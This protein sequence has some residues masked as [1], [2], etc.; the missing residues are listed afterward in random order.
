VGARTIAEG[1]ACTGVIGSS[2]CAVTTAVMPT[3]ALTRRQREFLQVLHRSLCTQATWLMHL[4][5]VEEA[6]WQLLMELVAALGAS[7]KWPLGVK[8]G[9]LPHQLLLNVRSALRQA[10]FDASPQQQPL[11]IH[12]LM[13]ALSGCCTG[14][15]RVRLG[16]GLG[17]GDGH[18]SSPPSCW[19]LPVTR[20]TKTLGVTWGSPSASPKR[21]N[22]HSRLNP[23]GRPM[24]QQQQEQKEE[25]QDEQQ[26]KQ[27]PC[28][29]R[30][31]PPP[32]PPHQHHQASFAARGRALRLSLDIP[33]DS[34]RD[35]CGGDG[36]YTDPRGAAL[37]VTPMTATA[38]H[39]GGCGGYA[40]ASAATGR[41]P[42]AHP[43][44]LPSFRAS[45]TSAAGV[46][47]GSGGAAIKPSIKRERSAA[48][49]SV[50][51]PFSP[52]SSTANRGSFRST[53]AGAANSGGPAGNAYSI[54]YERQLAAA[55]AAASPCRAR[56]PSPG[57]L[58][59]PSHYHQQQQQQ[60]QQQQ[61][62]ELQHQGQGQGRL[63][64]LLGR[65]RL[66]AAAAKAEE[67]SRP[68]PTSC[69][70]VAL[71]SGRPIMALVAAGGVVLAAPQEPACYVLSCQQDG[72]L[73]VTAKLPL[74]HLDAAYADKLA[75]SPDGGTAALSVA[76]LSLLPL[77]PAPP[78]PQPQPLQQHRPWPVY[79][80]PRQVGAGAA[81]AP[82]PAPATAAAA[83]AASDAIRSRV[84][85]VV[86]LRAGR[87]A[88]ELQ[89]ASHSRVTALV[90]SP[91]ANLLA[92]GCAASWARLWD[93]RL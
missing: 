25:V 76:P 90:L 93:A 28:H 56:L 7:R 70:S 29:L 62:L 50:G 69:C 14:T 64:S 4:G 35:D 23:S 24:R 72:G 51:C 49:T 18:P 37:F 27:Q 20:R 13:M 12:M 81:P 63:L 36:R 47:A 41:S 73:R 39:A 5:V 68:T 89:L 26:Q 65:S 38:R 44:T 83:T 53:S 3:E 67:G 16:I 9:E 52:T 61:E 17:T 66:G 34:G 80:E 32:P 77:M 15:A 58:G 87:I 57:S 30:V 43:S 46:N 88:R 91:T 2:T 48:N 84:L 71:G 85:A 19:P 21:G 82:A 86:D 33:F 8:A 1:P 6:A 45:F 78:R 74:S 55:A 42:G 31:L 40:S 60:Q 22:Y 59:K 11:R 92:S 79:S 10:R 75:I 54:K